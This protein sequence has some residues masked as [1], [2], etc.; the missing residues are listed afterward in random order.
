MLEKLKDHYMI[1]LCCDENLSPFYEKL[2]M[3]KVAGM[4]IRNY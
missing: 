3:K 2:G 1:D 4:I